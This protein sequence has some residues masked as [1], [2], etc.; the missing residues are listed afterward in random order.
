MYVCTSTHEAGPYGV[1]EAAFCKI[2]VISTS[3]GFGSKFSSIKT[4]NTVDEA[5]T[6]I[7]ELNSD[8]KKLN[9]Y[10][11][12]VYLELTANLNWKDL[13]DKYWRP[14]IEKR[15]NE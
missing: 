13:C 15:I 4:F 5:V 2:P 9:D 11:E 8:T 12:S 7:K 14:L 1:A 6:I 10:I 3:V